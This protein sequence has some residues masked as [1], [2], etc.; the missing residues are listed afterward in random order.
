NASIVNASLSANPNLTAIVPMYNDAANA[1]LAALRAR[2]KVGTVKMFT[3]DGD[4]KIITAVR[5]GDIEAVVSQQPGPQADKTL[6]LTLDA[7]RGR[8]YSGTAVGRD[9][10]KDVPEGRADPDGAD[11]QEQRRQP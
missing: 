3:F 5:N 4:P 11:R 10:R 7:T 2:N 8:E 1:A 6:A 9:R